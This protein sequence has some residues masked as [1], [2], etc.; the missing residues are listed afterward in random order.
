MAEDNGFDVACYSMALKKI[1]G[2]ALH[3]EQR[4]HLKRKFGV[5]ARCQTFVDGHKEYRSYGDSNNL[6]A[7]AREALKLINMNRSCVQEERLRN[8]DAKE[9]D[10]NP[11][12]RKCAKVSPPKDDDADTEESDGNC[13]PRRKAKV[14]TTMSE[15]LKEAID[16]IQMLHE[17]VDLF[18][19]TVSTLCK[20][21]DAI[22]N[23]FGIDP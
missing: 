7:C 8:T 22:H 16:T 2:T 19:S 17:K 4:A 21:V 1:D 11:R 3:S 13:R 23:A 20:K 15:S 14:S 5:S 10:D 12:P 18:G 6:H 9:A